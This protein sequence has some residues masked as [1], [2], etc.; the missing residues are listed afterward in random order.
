[1][2]INHVIMGIASCLTSSCIKACAQIVMAKRQT[3]I[4]MEFNTAIDI[5]KVE[6]K[7]EG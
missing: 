7:A 6:V 5:N 4:E 3:V 2:R 1:M